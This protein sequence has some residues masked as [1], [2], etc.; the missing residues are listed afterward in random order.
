MT[1]CYV[2]KGS[3]ALSDGVCIDSA[4][5]L[6]MGGQ[7]TGTGRFGRTCD[8][9]SS[10]PLVVSGPG[11]VLPKEQAATVCIGRKDAS[12]NTCSCSKALP[13]CHTCLVDGQGVPQS[14]MSC[15]NSRALDADACISQDACGA[16]KGFRV[17]GSGKFGVRCVSASA[18]S[19][20]P[21]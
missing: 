20:P 17:A 5:C 15:K 12:G 14:C 8:K 4:K 2:C 10:N 7:V 6:S 3:Q 9:A 18:A 16:K 21:A 19:G 13:H 11:G 1:S